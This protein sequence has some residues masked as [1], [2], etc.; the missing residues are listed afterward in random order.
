MRHSR[1][2]VVV[3]FILAAVG[4]VA[5]GGPSSPSSATTDVVLHGVI[6]GGSAG[7]GAAAFSGNATGEPIIV[8]V[9]GTS[10]TTTVG[11]DGSFTLRGLPTG[12]FTLVFTQGA[13]TLGTATFAEVKPNQEI[14]VTIE[15]TPS[16]VNVVEERRTGIGHGDTEIEGLVQQVLELNPVGDSRFLIDGKEVVARLGQT[17]IR[18]GNTAKTVN[19]VLVG[20]QVHVKG[21]FM[22][23][24]GGVTPVL[25]SEIMLQ[26]PEA[27]PSPSPEPTPSPESKCF[28]PGAKAEVEGK[29]T[30][31]GGGDITIAQQGKGDFQCFVGAGT[32]IRKGNTTYTFD[33]LQ[34]GWRVHVS[35]TGLGESGD[36]CLVQASEVKVQ[37]N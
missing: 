27:A 8:T 25:A 29:I 17:A 34:P 14:T 2:I 15:V 4:L 28:A 11:D 10:I 31:K 18:E 30:A 24:V 1:S 13:V 35:G 5:C 16:G 32:P 37:Q 23:P 26:E 21:T 6:M 3:L 20:R 36:L 12:S 33:Q 9:Q 22:D 19:D 7:G